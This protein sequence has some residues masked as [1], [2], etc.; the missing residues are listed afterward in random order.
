MSKRVTSIRISPDIKEELEQRAREAGVPSAALY[1]RFINEGLRHDAHPIIVF[2]DGAAGRRAVIAGTRTTVA[3][4]IDTVLATDD[5]SITQA[6]EYLG[7]PESHVSECVR[8]YA[9]YRDEID[10]WRNRLAEIAERER[11][12]W[13][14]EQA[15][16]A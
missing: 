11:D 12:A 4:V 7:L 5:H 15:V 9:S 6:A 2:R 10:E 16:L 14:R 3:Q 13:Q 1:E 8:Y